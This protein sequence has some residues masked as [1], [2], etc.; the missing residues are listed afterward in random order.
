MTSARSHAQKCCAIEEGSGPLSCGEV[1]TNAGTEGLMHHGV[2]REP[3]GVRMMRTPLIDEEVPVV[4]ETPRPCGKLCTTVSFGSPSSLTRSNL[5]ASSKGRMKV[6]GHSLE[7]S[8]G[9]TGAKEAVRASVIC[10]RVS[11][12]RRTGRIVPVAFRRA[13]VAKKHT[14]EA[15][16][17]VVGS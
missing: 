15:F 2:V 10:G 9:L 5:R 8:G 1:V 6:A 12:L 7:S 11:R 16:A 4:V 13:P 3:A 17:R 14:V